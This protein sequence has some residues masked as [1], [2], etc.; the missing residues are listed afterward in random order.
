MEEVLRRTASQR[1]TNYRK[2]HKKIR[3]YSIRVYRK[4]IIQLI[5]CCLI[6]ISI[7]SVRSIDNPLAK[8]MI[9]RINDCIS[10]SIDWGNTYESINIWFSNIASF[11]KTLMNQEGNQVKDQGKEV[12]KENNK[13]TSKIN[14]ISKEEQQ[15]AVVPDESQK[16]SGKEVKPV[17]SSMNSMDIDVK[18]I[19]SK[20][21]LALPVNSTISSRYGMRINP[22]THKEELHPGVD[23][24]AN[25]GTPIHAAFAGEVIESRKGT[26]FGN[27]IKIKTEKD[28]ISVYAHCSKLLVKNGQKVVKGQTIGKVGSTGMSLGPHL[29]FEVWRDDRTVNP[30]SLLNFKK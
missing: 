15:K 27:F 26:T 12:Q 9:K 25:T 7:V 30:A 28:I 29:H 1:N 10:S 19:K 11:P 4:I 22:I 13:E 18:Y 6:L 23:I 8:D 5:I 14:N 16:T 2:K 3:I 20:Y 21:K 24:P 17:F